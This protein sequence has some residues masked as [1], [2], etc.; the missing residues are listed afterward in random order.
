MEVFDL[1][2]GALEMIEGLDCVRGGLTGCGVD[3]EVRRGKV[4]KD[5]GCRRPVKTCAVASAKEM[6]TN[7]LVSEVFGVIVRRASAP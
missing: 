1:N 5:E 3:L 6:V 2:V 7:A 4:I